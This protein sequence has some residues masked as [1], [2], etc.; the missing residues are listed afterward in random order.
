MNCKPGDIARVVPDLPCDEWGRGF[1]VEV[2]EPCVMDGQPCW[3]ITPALVSPHGLVVKAIEDCILR[4]IRGDGLSH[5]DV[6]RLFSTQPIPREF[7]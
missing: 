4:P 1:I 5:E 2:K 3:F 7:A 6:D